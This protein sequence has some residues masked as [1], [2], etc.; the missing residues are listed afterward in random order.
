MDIAYSGYQHIPTLMVSP[1]A[2]EH[3]VAVCAPSKT[4]NLGG[5]IGSYHMIYNDYLRIRMNMASPLSP[6]RRRLT[7][8]TTMCSRHKKKRPNV[9]TDKKGAV[10]G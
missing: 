8:W 3:T 10:K 4:F 5:R 9:R 6:F 1:W 7:A 2:R